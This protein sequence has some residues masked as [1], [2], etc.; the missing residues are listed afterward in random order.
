M[1][2]IT[3]E[4]VTYLEA[5][6]TEQM[7]DIYLKTM[8]RKE[9]KI[10]QKF[11]FMLA[12]ISELF[13]YHFFCR[14]CVPHGNSPSTDVVLGCQPEGVTQSRAQLGQLAMLLAPKVTFSETT[15]PLSLEREEESVI[16][17]L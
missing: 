2:D 7:S 3:K 5:L 6:I 10:P 11:L 15:V 13:K 1:K 8:K 16:G 12:M 4:S 9:T 17:S 14:K